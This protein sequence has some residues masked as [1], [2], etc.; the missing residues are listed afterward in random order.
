MLKNS[1]ANIF[2]T[3]SF[4]PHGF[5]F[6][7]ETLGRIEEL[8][9]LINMNV[10]IFLRLLCADFDQRGRVFQKRSFFLVS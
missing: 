10:L 6:F 9:L 7:D 2:K 4:P 3:E 8:R 5:I 1:T